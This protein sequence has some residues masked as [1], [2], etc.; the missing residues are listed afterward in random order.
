[1]ASAKA[2][3]PDLSTEKLDRDMKRQLEQRAAAKGRMGF[4]TQQVKAMRDLTT[5][6]CFKG[7]MSDKDL[8]YW[9]DK[10]KATAKFVEP[11]KYDAFV[12]EQVLSMINGARRQPAEVQARLLNMLEEKNIGSIDIRND[13]ERLVDG[14]VYVDAP[15]HP[16]TLD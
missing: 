12:N 10:L 7:L 5:I 9:S 11:Q 15:E 16:T 6:A 8:N 2:L 3:T 4:N 1:M 13:F 14:T